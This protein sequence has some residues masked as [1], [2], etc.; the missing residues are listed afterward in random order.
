VP[1]DGDDALVGRLVVGRLEDLD[2]VEAAERDIGGEE[3]P[4]TLPDGAI[5]LLHP[6][7]P[8]R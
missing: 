3:L 8:A 1:C 5:S 4:A 7:P 2:H 6:I